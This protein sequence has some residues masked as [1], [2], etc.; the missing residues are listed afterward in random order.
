MSRSTRTLTSVSIPNIAST[1]PKPSSATRVISAQ[2]SG[3]TRRLWISKRSRNIPRRIADRDQHQ[4][5]AAERLDQQAVEQEADREAG[6]RAGH[7]PAEEA[8]ADDQ[9]GQH[10][11][12]DVEEFDLGEEGQ[13]QEHAEEPDD[14]QADD[15]FRGQDHLR[16]P[17]VST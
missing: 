14:D 3:T 4:R 16:V 9:R 2:S 5:G 13:L 7:R 12:A 6:D 10:V 1:A 8:E 11:G 17:P 15:D